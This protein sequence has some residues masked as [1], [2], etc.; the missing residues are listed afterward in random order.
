MDLKI[1]S[2]VGTH[3]FSVFCFNNFLENMK[4]SKVSP[5]NL[6][7]DTDIFLFCLSTGST[8]E[9]ENVPT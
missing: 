4:K 5:V 2:R 7:R 6:G 9:D 1:L 8:Q 3:I